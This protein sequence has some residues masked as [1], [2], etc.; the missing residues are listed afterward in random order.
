VRKVA[1]G[2]PIKRCDVDEKFTDEINYLLLLRALIEEEGIF[3][4]EREGLV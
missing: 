4:P 1:F 2:D 3:A